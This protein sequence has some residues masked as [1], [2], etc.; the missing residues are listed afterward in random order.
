MNNPS[1]AQELPTHYHK[2]LLLFDPKEAEKLP[3]TKDSDRRIELLG[4]EDKLQ[5]GPIYQLSQVEE[6][7][8]IK[9]LDTM[10]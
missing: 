7:L 5:M 1:I 9:Y 8:L 4:H 3:D 2:F 6:K 10:I